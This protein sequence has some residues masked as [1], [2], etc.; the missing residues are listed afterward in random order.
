MC[1]TASK[2][3]IGAFAHLL[4]VSRW[5]D[6]IANTFSQTHVKSAILFCPALS[7][8]VLPVPYSALRS[9]ARVDLLIFKKIVFGTRAETQLLRLSYYDR[10]D[11]RPPHGPPGQQACLAR[12]ARSWLPE[13]AFTKRAP[14]SC[15]RATHSQGCDQEAR[16]RSCN[17][18]DCSSSG[19]SESRPGSGRMASAK[20][21]SRSRSPP[22]GS[23]S[24]RAP[25]PP[26]PPVSTKSVNSDTFDPCVRKH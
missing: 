23:R 8:H 25:S 26:W 5:F 21:G 11:P 24:Q 18:C 10:P 1:H 9:P 14:R 16:S 2:G 3:S 6:V 13:Q 17:L 4:G 22:S 7:F 20:D 12:R 15:T 19:L